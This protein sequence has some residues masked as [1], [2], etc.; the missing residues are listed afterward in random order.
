MPSPRGSRARIR[1]ALGRAVLCGAAALWVVGCAKDPPVSAAK[2]KPGKSAKRPAA[3]KK[4]A[5]PEAEG[6]CIN[7]KAVSNFRVLDRTRVLVNTY[8]QRVIELYDTCDGVK[9]MDELTFAGTGGIICDY[10]SDALI[11]NGVRCTIASIKEYEG[12]SEV[13]LRKEIENAKPEGSKKSS[14]PAEKPD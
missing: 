2:S 12:D 6:I 5:L 1:T 8:P 14:K 11:V 9:F 4:T 13:E 10:R 3:K 7:P